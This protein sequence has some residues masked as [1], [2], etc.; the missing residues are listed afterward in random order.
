MTDQYNNKK[1]Q[2]VIN[3]LKETLRKTQNEIGDKL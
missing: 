1:Y 2:K 3:E